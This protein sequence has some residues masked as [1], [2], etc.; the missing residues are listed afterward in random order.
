MILFVPST[1]AIN[2]ILVT[3]CIRISTVHY[4][5][6]SKVLNFVDV[7]G[8]LS[9]AMYTILVYLFDVD[10]TLPEVMFTILVYLFDVD[11]TL[12]KLMYTI[13]VY[14]SCARN[15]Q[16]Q[17]RCIRSLADVRQVYHEQVVVQHRRGGRG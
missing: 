11:G 5:H 17:M 10:G 9:E 15:T 8:T 3:Y 4:A 14:L 6:I 16:A 12:T 7:D 13:L 2:D 1:S